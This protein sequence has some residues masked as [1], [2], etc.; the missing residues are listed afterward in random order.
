MNQSLKDN[1]AQSPLPWPPDYVAEYRRRLELAHRLESDRAAQ[2]AMMRYYKYR[3][4]EWIQD[5]G[6]TFD[7]RL[8]GRKK[9]PFILFKK[10]KDFVLYL[11]QLWKTGESGLTEKCRDIGAS[12]LCVM[13]SVWLWIFHDGST[14][15]WGSRKEEY[16]DDKGNPKAIFPK[17]RQQIENLPTWM[18]PSGFDM[19][20]HATYMKIINP[21]NEATIIGEAGD[22][23]GRGGRT[24]IYFK[25]ESAHYEHPEEV[26]AAL[27][28]NTDVQVDISSV[29][30]SANVFYRR[31]MAGEIWLPDKVMPHG[32]TWVFIFDWRDHPGKT[33]EWYDTRRAKAEAEG[34]LH[35]FAQ[36]VD[37]DYSGSVE[38]IIIPAEWVRAAIG[39]HKKLAKWGNWFAGEH[40]A[41]QDVADGG[42]DRNAL[43]GRWGSVVNLAEH[44]G[45]E[46]PD[47]PPIAVPM[48]LENNMHE[49]YYDSI[50][51]GAGYKGTINRMMQTKSWPSRLRVMKWNAAAAPLDPDDPVIPGDEQSPTN[52][53]QYGNLKAQSAFRL[54][55][56][57]YK[58]Y[59]AITKG[60]RYPVEEMISLDENLAHL[61]ELVMECSQPVKKTGTNG[62]TIIDKKPAGARS[63][64]LFDGLNMCFNPTREVSIYDV[65]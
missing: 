5:W 12:W 16:V 40:V 54:R 32:R 21:A 61:H 53:D 39:A 43:V 19:K 31:R 24:S 38:G 63:P 27:G 56:R 9:I 14:V 23:I 22:S 11:Y 34:L 46:A 49:L 29:N 52:E 48:C 26:E 50:G 60:D 6:I 47:A 55:S 65:L 30:G 64:N 17:I 4:V 7:P 62:K 36:E 18:L 33:Q 8:K 57:F 15:G 28:D 13:F 58:T 59:K 35:I 42:G 3:P 37:R 10:Q 1:I 45:G 41:A 51:V 2:L 44:W 20:K 25:D